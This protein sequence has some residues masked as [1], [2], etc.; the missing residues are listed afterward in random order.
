MIKYFFKVEFDN[1]F[2]K[3]KAVSDYAGMLTRFIIVLGIVMFLIFKIKTIQN[4]D[5]CYYLYYG[6]ILVPFVFLALI[7]LWSIVILT[8]STVFRSLGYSG[9]DPVKGWKVLFVV[10]L[11]F[12]FIILLSIFMIELTVLSSGY[13]NMVSQLAEKH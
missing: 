8:T 1:A 5:I 2:D 4:N 12:I 9:N 3:A 7:M 13:K 10:S 11:L 6:A